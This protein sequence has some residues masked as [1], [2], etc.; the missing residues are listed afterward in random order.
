MSFPKCCQLDI[1]YI[2][3]HFAQFL[4][5][6]PFQITKYNGCNLWTVKWNVH[7]K[8]LFQ[9][10]WDWENKKPTERNTYLRPVTGNFCRG[11][12]RRINRDGNTLL[13]SQTTLNYIKFNLT[14]G[15]TSPCPPLPPVMALLSSIQYSLL[16][17]ENGV[18]QY[19]YCIVEYY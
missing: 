10:W 3:L 4:A 5:K 6:A 19:G 15:G 14:G 17:V 18:R 16:R 2:F 8:L 9:I 13:H 7:F 11:G 1:L 12:A